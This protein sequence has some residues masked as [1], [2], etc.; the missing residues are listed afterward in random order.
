M[1]FSF[2]NLVKLYKLL[3]NSIRNIFDNNKLV[4]QKGIIQFQKRGNKILVKQNNQSK[5]YKYLNEET[6]WLEVKNKNIFNNVFINFK[7][8]K[9]IT[10]EIEVV[11]R[12]SIVIG[13]LSGITFK[14]LQG[15]FTRFDLIFR[16]C[17]FLET[18][19]DALD[20]S[21]DFSNCSHSNFN[22]I[23]CTFFD[24][25][26]LNRL[27]D[28]SQIRFLT[29]MF[30]KNTI[31]I[32]NATLHYFGIW[33]TE[34]SN[35]Q[36]LTELD[37]SNCNINRLYLDG[38]KVTSLKVYGCIFK[39]RVI[40]DIVSK[41]IIFMESTFLDQLSTSI[42]GEYENE[43]TKLD[44]LNFIG[45]N[46][47]EKL[48][49][50]NTVCEIIDINDCNIEKGLEI[51]NFDEILSGKTNKLTSALLIHNSR[52]YGFSQIDTSK[53]DFLNFSG[54]KFFGYLK[55]TPNDFS[56]II[57]RIFPESEHKNSK[58]VFKDLKQQ[59]WELG[60]VFHKND[61]RDNE[62][63]AW[64]EYMRLTRKLAKW[65]TKIAYFAIEFT[66]HYGTK[67]FR[68]AIMGIFV[69]ILWAFFYGI[70]DSICFQVVNS[71]DLMFNIKIDSVWNY[72]YFS[73][74]TFFTIGYGDIAPLHWIAKILAGFEGGLGVFFIAFFTVS[75]FKKFTR[76]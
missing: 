3:M 53:I 56:K 19:S 4:P 69:M 73:V 12:N 65:Y 59:Y 71:K 75:V 29:C 63:L 67:P 16:K 7:G 76:N 54:S 24:D 18:I 31:N 74:I 57:K 10:E 23:F 9:N 35:E 46:F 26:R 1:K 33:D 60:K 2:K 47:N 20:N 22:F 52:I 64:V 55:I 72:L 61:E 66:G 30:N 38:L 44:Y 41:N 11:F 58:L 21:Y 8:R 34:R 39:K 28:K 17:T 27:E 43:A 15:T 51:R 70:F 36:Y 37:I 42:A 50:G 40:Y 14:K 6:F 13:E 32:D 68:I 5:E 48:S 49:F 62:N 25:L 45:C